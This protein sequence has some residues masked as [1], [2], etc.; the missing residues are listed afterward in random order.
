MVGEAFHLVCSGTLPAGSPPR[1]PT[2]VHR[3]I[4]GPT[5][6]SCFDE[7]SFLGVGCGLG[8]CSL[9]GASKVSPSGGKERSS[10]RQRLWNV[11]VRHALSSQTQSGSATRIEYL[12]CTRSNSPLGLRV[13]RPWR[14]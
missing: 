8:H 13:A 1:Q 14:T 3:A 11:T 2:G 4:P 5:R 6:V 10:R 12:L 7:F 9:H